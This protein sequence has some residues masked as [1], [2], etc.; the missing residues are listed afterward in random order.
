MT[1]NITGSVHAIGDAI[2]E[3]FP[4]IINKNGA[5]F[6][7]LL[8]D[9]TQTGTIEEICCDVEKIREWWARTNDFYDLQGTPLTKAF[10]S[11]SIIQRDLNDTDGVVRILG[12]LIFMRMGDMIWGGV[13]NT[14]RT[15]RAFF[16]DNEYVYIVNNT[17]DI[18]ENMIQDAGFDNISAWKIKNCHCDKSRERFYGEKSIVFDAFA[19]VSQ[20]VTITD[21]E[22]AV[23][24]LHLF[25]KGNVNVSIID[26][27]NRYWH[28]TKDCLGEWKDGAVNISFTSNKWEDKSVFI[29]NYDNIQSVNIVITGEANSSIDYVRMFKKPPFPT[30]SLITVFGKPIT[31]KTAHYELNGG[32]VV[33]D[34]YGFL[35]DKEVNYR[36]IISYFETHYILGGQGAMAARTYMK[37]LEILKPAGVISYI[38]LLECN[39]EESK[40]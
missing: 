39:R 35:K 5:I 32:D 20:E 23:Y 10:N 21:K 30:F 22:N 15:L 4:T 34:G 25:I 37:M 3:A 40:N 13:D 6:K 29:R 36:D 19:Q 11:M 24:Y 26:N 27:K 8:A 14:Q 18:S 33:K 16:N 12:R 9:N 1:E 17:C 2:K 31:Q 38:D 28:M 7:A